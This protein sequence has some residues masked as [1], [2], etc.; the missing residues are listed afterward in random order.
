MNV[1]Y[2]YKRPEPAGPNPL[3]TPASWLYRF[4]SG[5]HRW[6]R[7]RP[8][9]PENTEALIISV[10]NLEAGGGGKTPFCILLLERLL[11]RGDRSVYI[12]RGYG[13]E[14][15][16]SGVVTVVSPSEPAPGLYRRAR[17]RIVDRRSPGL[18]AAVGD[19]GAVVARAV[20]DAPLLFAGRKNSA[21][22]AAVE[23]FDPTHIILDD[24]FQS[25]GVYRDLDIVLLDSKSPAGNG[26]LVPA[27]SLRE[28]PAGLRRADW[29]GLNDIGDEGELG[30]PAAAWL[31]DV[32]PGVP[33]G[34]I[35]RSLGFRTP[36]GRLEAPDDRPVAA[37]SS[38]A[39]PEAFESLLEKS[40]W[41]IGLALR[42]PDHFPY[43]PG[44]IPEIRKY[45]AGQDLSR[46]VTT[47]KDWVKLES[48]MPGDGVVVLA[49]LELTLIGADPLLAERKP[50]MESILRKP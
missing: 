10:G 16:G 47:E 33:V 48:L 31:A 23:L 27:G 44:D 30:G 17:L 29:I 12:S 26:R 2:P 22:A 25:W 39:R 1:I 18:A 5:I 19:E 38:I 11:G 49:G 13:S 28:S 14:A 3:L 21:L 6:M 20:P 43:R 32:A 4:G 7:M 46:L 34:G 24:A 41:K 9:R 35:R 36:D 15:G 50:P 42:Y 37:L 8:R 45:L 40:G